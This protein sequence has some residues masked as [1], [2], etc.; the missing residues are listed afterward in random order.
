MALEVF[1]GGTVSLSDDV[2]M[3]AWMTFPFLFGL[4]RQKIYD[5]KFE[6]DI[7]CVKLLNG[8]TRKELKSS[9]FV[10]NARNKPKEAMKQEISDI[11]EEANYKMEIN[12]MFL[13]ILKLHLILRNYQKVHRT[14]DT[15]FRY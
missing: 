5:E 4:S 12:F 6:I 10:K 15:L 1:R 3:V 13:D 14:H 2:I 8:S 7:V 9:L 11:F